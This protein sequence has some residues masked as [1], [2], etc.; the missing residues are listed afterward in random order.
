MSKPNR[1]TGLARGGSSC[2]LRR[3]RGNW[4]KDISGGLNGRRWDEGRPE[5]TSNQN[6]GM[7]LIGS[8]KMDLMLCNPFL[9][10]Y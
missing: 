9:Q 1:A 3:D 7:A 4:G 10:S 2:P 6:G 8:C 5:V